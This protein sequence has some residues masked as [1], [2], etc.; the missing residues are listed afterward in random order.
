M[1]QQVD[2][3]RDDVPT[4]LRFAKVPAGVPDESTWRFTHDPTR[5]P[6]ASEVTLRLEYLS[7]DPA[8]VGWIAPKKSYIEAVPKGEVMRAFGVGRV[9][10]SRFPGLSSGDCAFGFTGARTE[11][12]MNGRMLRPIDPGVAP[13]TA[14]FGL[15]DIGQPKAGETVVVSA[16]A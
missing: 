2:E 13:L 9:V 5:E 4:Q 1:S 16:A 7:V 6:E 15:L 8:M 11:V 14:Y 12:T 10:A 3:R